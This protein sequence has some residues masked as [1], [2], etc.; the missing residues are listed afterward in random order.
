MEVDQ[1]DNFSPAD[2]RY[3]IQDLSIQDITSPERPEDKRKEE[4]EVVNAIQEVRRS[5]E[6][7]QSLLSSVNVSPINHSMNSFAHY[8]IVD[9]PGAC[10]TR[11]RG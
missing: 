6:Q 8:P 3:R 10:I 5:L 7:K 11:R 9:V 1:I 2:L 4:R